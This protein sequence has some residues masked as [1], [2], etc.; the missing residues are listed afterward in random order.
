[1]AIASPLQRGEDGVGVY[2]NVVS[3]ELVVLIEVIV[4]S[5]LARTANGKQP[6]LEAAIA[7]SRDSVITNG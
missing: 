4:L 5:P 7:F 2:N 3:V 1:M 6:A